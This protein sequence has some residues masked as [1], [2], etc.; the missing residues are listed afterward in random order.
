MAREVE[1]KPS[2]SRMGTTLT[3]LLIR[4][5]GAWVGHVGDSRLAWQRGGEL[6]LVTQDHSLAWE[7]VEAGLLSPDVAE[8]DP[9]GSV[10]T[11]HMGPIGAIKP[12]IFERPLRLASG[13]RL[14]LLTD[15]LGKVV[16]MDEVARVVREQSVDGAVRDLIR[17]TRD[18]GAPD[19]VTVMIAL[20]VE[21]PDPPGPAVAW[22]EPRYRWKA[23]G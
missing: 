15:G 11:R 23:R 22:E 9:S 8:Q 10:L 14:L 7:M 4:D 6:C 18:G 16:P 17:L 2:L 5:D 20:I 3:V 13:D 19:N 21:P 1:T 12:D